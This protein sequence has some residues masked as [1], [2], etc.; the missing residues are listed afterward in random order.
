MTAIVRALAM[1][2]ILTTVVGCSFGT[3]KVATYDYTPYV[4]NNPRSVLVAPMLAQGEHARHYLATVAQPLAERGYY[5]MPIRLTQ[6]LLAAEGYQ[7][8]AREL[9]STWRTEEGGS[10][11]DLIDETKHPGIREM[12]IELAELT[13]A[14]SVLFVYIRDWRHEVDVSEGFLAN[15]VDERMNHHIDLDYLL[16]GAE[17][18]TLWRARKGVEYTRGGGGFFTEIWNARHK[19][20]DDEIDTAIARDVNRLMIE[21]QRTRN[22]MTGNWFPSYPMLVGPYHPAYEADRMRRQ[23]GAQ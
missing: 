7:E 21:A 2:A 11:W 16:I 8:R 3:R 23:P 15:L 19:A 17:G 12:A 9:R 6:D 18:D 13:G 5:V 20:S 4:A 1:L 14:D 10:V 22:E